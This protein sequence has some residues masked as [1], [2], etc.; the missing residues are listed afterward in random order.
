[1]WL[2]DMDFKAPQPVIQALR[3]RVDHGVFGYGK[4]PKALNEAILKHLSYYFNW[5][6]DSEAISFVCGVVTGFVH[7]IYS[8][9]EPG[10]RVLIQ[11][12]V[13]PPILR[14]PKATGREPVYN[15][16]ILGDDG[17][18]AIDFD[19]FE[20]KIATGV[21]LFILCN[22]H[23]PVGRVFTREELSKMAEI[24]LKYNVW[25]CSDEIHHD[26]IFSGC[27]H[28]PIASLSPEAAQATVTYFAPSKTFNIAG[29]S[30]SVAL[31]ENPV[32]K[33]KLQQTLSML[34]GHP[35][36]FGLTAA[37]AAYQE[38]RP[39]LQEMI[40]YLEANRDFLVDFITDSL[41][42]IKIWKPEGTFLGWLDCRQLDVESPHAFFLEKARV[43]FN[44][45]LSFGE[46]GR[47]FLRINFGCPRATLIEGL[48][49]MQAALERS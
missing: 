41:P 8:L 10:D 27:Q 49:R 4:A 43:G 36:I 44:D 20:A 32:I 25:I 30:T 5:S 3:D 15:P 28:I 13:Y 21:K 35:N 48:T 29:L 22:P 38:G 40:S 24:C 46:D 2:A 1:M 19:D 45:G 39:W 11:T 9:T 37:R 17:K 12:P 23:N 47:G 18:Y 33:D 42:D 26:L 34:L 16:L 14:A 7:A 6:V 31:A